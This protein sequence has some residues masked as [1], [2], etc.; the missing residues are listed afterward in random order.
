MPYNTICPIC[1]RQV[2]LKGKWALGRHLSAKQHQ[3]LKEQIQSSNDERSILLYKAVCVWETEHNAK[4]ALQTYNHSQEGKESEVM[5]KRQDLERESSTEIWNPFE[6]VAAEGVLTDKKSIGILVHDTSSEIFDSLEMEDVPDNDDNAADV[7]Y[8]EDDDSSK[9]GEEI[10][11]ESESENA[12][13]IIDSADEL[14]LDQELAELQDDLQVEPQS[15]EDLYGKNPYFQT[16]YFSHGTD[17]LTIEN[18]EGAFYPFS[19]RVEFLLYCFC[20]QSKLSQNQLKSVWWLLEALMPG[21]KI[22]SMKK[23]LGMLL[24]ISERVLK[25]MKI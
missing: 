5:K 3:K 8:E 4:D 23:I 14:E 24:M 15:A 19:D 21:Q 9:E 1:P 13:E 25:L 11:Y 7:Q 2:Y 22:P 18:P 17:T 6:G 16:S 12:L 10:E 20:M